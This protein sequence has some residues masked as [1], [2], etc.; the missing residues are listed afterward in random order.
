MNIFKSLEEEIYNT[1]DVL[2]RSGVISREIVIGSISVEPPR[3][4]AH[5]DVSTNAALVL[6][7]PAKCKPRDLAK[8]LVPKL[9]QIRD[10]I[11][12]DI[13]GP[14]FLN[15]RLQNDYWWRLL[16]EVLDSGSE[17]GRNE[18][19]AGRKVIVE[20]VS[21][22]P[23]G[24]LHV[25]HA[26]GAVFGDVLSRL[27]KFSGF[28]VTREYYWNDAGAQVDKLAAA[29]YWRY[30]QKLDGDTPATAAYE[31][32]Q[33]VGGYTGD[34][35][36][37]VGTTL[38]EAEGD[39]WRDVPETGWL[40]DIRAV[41]VE[42]MKALIRED[43]SAL[44]A[45]FDSEVSESGLVAE[46]KVDAAIKALELRGLIYRGQL[47]PPK[48]RVDDW[49]AREQTL[50]CS[51]KFGDQ[52]DRPL[53]K[54][55]GT[56]TYF[57]TDIAYHLDKFNRGHR[58]MINVW[59]A[60]HGGY[61][62]RVKAAVEALTDGAA[63]L[64]VKL[65]QMVRLFDGGNPVKMSKRSGNFVTVRNLIEAMDE[66]VGGQLGKDVVRFIM[67]TRKNDAPL[68]FDFAKA[69]EQSRDNPVFYVQYANARICSVRRRVE[70]D[71]ALNR[72]ADISDLARLKRPDE[73]ALIRLLAD[74]P[75]QVETAAGSCEPHRLAFYLYDLASAFHAL[76]NKG[77]DDP[78]ARFITEND[79]GLTRARLALIK[80][81]Q[82]VIV[83]G[84]ENLFGVTP[85]DEMR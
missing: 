39:K 3:D 47:E 38:A 77:N 30:L 24:P 69:A 2:K 83:G 14:G 12:V 40:P 48:G 66:R 5:G 9:K 51:T 29:V 57:A 58:E 41:S 80:A 54:S 36:V 67:L 20:F 52:V 15:F 11:S 50:F 10:V 53:Q 13:A 45:E 23:T 1:L 28:D 35:L 6:A 79:P 7:G 65:C 18:L 62:S 37:D 71:G 56:W 21:A 75:R 85:Q 68:D 72:P 16:K 60:D 76:W 49:E 42:A 82:I 19:G 4:P 17:Y 32:D 44:G 46:A 84:L 27:L 70:G 22:N 34:Y 43:L 55:D 25:G 8:L 59:G 61:V 74:W 73:L 33:E 63:N 78:N 26:R 64:D 31:P 81:V